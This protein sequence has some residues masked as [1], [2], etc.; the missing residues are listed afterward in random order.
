M[1]ILAW[2]LSI[3]LAGTFLS[4]GIGKLVTPRDK[5]L[6]N[7]RL[8]WAEDFSDR[9]VKI[10][11]TL[12]VLGGIGVI[13]PWATGIAPVLTPIAAL[14]L[15]AVMIGAMVTHTRRGE[16]KQAGPINVSLLVLALAV[17]IIRFTQL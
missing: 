11:G 5:M 7:P 17:A 12:E 1:S 6:A 8:S 15:G 16:I 13:L 3:L 2:I 4:A 9:A 10:I 14:G